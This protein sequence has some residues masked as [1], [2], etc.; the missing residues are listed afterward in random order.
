MVAQP[1]GHTKAT[2]L[3]TSNGWIWW[4]VNLSHKAIFLKKLEGMTL[5]PLV[6]LSR[7]GPILSF[8]QLVPILHISFHSHFVALALSPPKRPELTW[9][10]MGPQ[11]CA[12]SKPL[13]HSSPWISALLA[14]Q[15]RVCLLLTC[16]CFTMCASDI[17]DVALFQIIFIFLVSCTSLRHMSGR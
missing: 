15:S 12:W 16:H 1:C 8:S 14:L 17:C 11:D 13:E 6:I 7:T 2:E 3:Y 10:F 4:Y 9:A 5:S